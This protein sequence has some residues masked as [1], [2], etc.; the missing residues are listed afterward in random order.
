MSITRIGGK[1]SN[2]LFYFYYS[3]Y[4]AFCHTKIPAFIIFLQKNFNISTRIK[5]YAESCLCPTTHFSRVSLL[6]QTMSRLYSTLATRL[7]Y[8]FGVI[9]YVILTFLRKTGDVYIIY[10]LITDQIMRDLPIIALDVQL[11]QICL[12]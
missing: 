3:S 12:P 2:K 6:F 5:K 1:A 10:R 9:I 8:Y 4:F 11:R 7:W